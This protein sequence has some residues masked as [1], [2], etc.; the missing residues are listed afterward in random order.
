MQA[1]SLYSTFGRELLA[2]YLAIRHFRHM[3][4]GRD[5]TIFTDHKLLIY[6]LHSVSDRYLPREVR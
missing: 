5:F 1:E 2:V 4:E 3:L 6:A